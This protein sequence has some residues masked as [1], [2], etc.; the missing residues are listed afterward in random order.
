MMEEIE[1]LNSQIENS[2]MYH[3]KEVNEITK[4]LTLKDQTIADLKMKKKVKVTSALDPLSREE[5]HSPDASPS[6]RTPR[7]VGERRFTLNMGLV[8]Q[9]QKEQEEEEGAETPKNNPMFQLDEAPEVESQ[10]DNSVLT[11]EDLEIEDG[12]NAE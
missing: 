9:I 4:K 12:G 5:S 1:L 11:E 7:V 6:S 2:Q 8:E 3:E 10:S